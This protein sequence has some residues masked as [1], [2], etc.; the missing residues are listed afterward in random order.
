MRGIG[1]FLRYH[2]KTQGARPETETGDQ[3]P[4]TGD[5]RQRPETRDVDVGYP[6]DSAIL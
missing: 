1:I 3:R 2:P 4:E 6:I 5:Q